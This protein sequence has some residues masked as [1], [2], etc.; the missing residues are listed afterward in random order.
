MK[1]L[2]FL[3]LFTFALGPAAALAQ[4]HGQVGIFVNYFREGRTETHFIGLGGRLG[5][6]VHENV[7]FEG[8]IAYDF[9]RAF[10]EGFT[11]TS[12]GSVTLQRTDLRV[13]HGMFGPKFQT[14]GAARAFFTVKAGFVHFRFD[15]RPATFATFTSTVEDLRANN[16]SFV[17]YPGAGLEAFWGPFGMR[18]DIGDEIYFRSGARHNLRITFGP[19]LRF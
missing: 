3:L 8:E 19:H 13:L 11:D 10:T 5:F 7:Q 17:L 9:Q 2:A 1:R 16:T 14:G 6:N 18:F 4:D 15:D 12:D